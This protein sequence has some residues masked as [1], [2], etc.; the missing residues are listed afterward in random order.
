MS[1]RA[2]FIAGGWDGHEP[3]E[4]SNFMIEEIKKFNI[5]SEIVQDLEVLADLKYLQ[6]FD[7][8]GSDIGLLFQIAD[9]LID[10]TGDTKKV[11]K[12]TK[13][14][15]KKGKATLISL[16]G[17]KNTIKYNNKLKLEIFKKL[18]KFGKKSKDLKNTIN[19]I[20]NRIK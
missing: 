9:D 10:F 4:T 1:K 13:K 19:Y 18:N 11:G 6:D 7:Q 12:K 20:V 3:L 15:L 5:E 17:H 16:L 8:I 2:L 14:D